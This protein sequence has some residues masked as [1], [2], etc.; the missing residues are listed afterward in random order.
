M[1]KV[2]SVLA[3]LAALVWFLVRVIPKPS[4]AAYPCQRAAFPLASGFV[5]WLVGLFCLKSLQR[6]VAGAAV[7]ALALLAVWLPLGVTSDAVAQNRPAPE[8]FQPSEGLNAPMGEAKGIY[9]GR[10][11]WVRDPD[12]TSW[13]GTHGKWWDDANTDAAA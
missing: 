6:R 1:R 7:L 12:A 9:P 4:R 10:V 5:V 11:A 3:G 2:L 13:D 8:P